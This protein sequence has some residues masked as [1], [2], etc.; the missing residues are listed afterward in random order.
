MSDINIQI[1]T[2]DN[3]VGLFTEALS[4]WTFENLMHKL[5]YDALKKIMNFWTSPI[6]FARGGSKPYAS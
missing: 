4:S 5:E 1:R 2:Y 3:L 6:M